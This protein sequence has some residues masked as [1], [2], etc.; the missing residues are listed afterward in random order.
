MGT[1]N[2]D[3]APTETPVTTSQMPPLRSSSMR[4]LSSLSRGFSRMS[5]GPV[6][7]FAKRMLERPSG[8]C[9][10]TTVSAALVN[11]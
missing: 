6:G 4:M 8:G 3:G 5:C 9:V 7:S 10:S 1:L 2:V 11:G